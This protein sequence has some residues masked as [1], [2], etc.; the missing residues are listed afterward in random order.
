ML[1]TKG[2][3]ATKDEANHRG[4]REHRGDEN[5]HGT[6]MNMDFGNMLVC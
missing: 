3:N 4:H 2:T 6:R 1:N 5:G